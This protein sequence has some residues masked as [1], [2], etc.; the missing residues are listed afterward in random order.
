[1]SIRLWLTPIDQ[2]Y[3]RKKIS[4]IISVAALAII[5]LLI[6]IATHRLDNLYEN[7]KSTVVSD[8]NGIPILILPN[9]RG[10]YSLFANDIP[11]TFADLLISKED[12]YFYYHTGINLVGTAQLT[13]SKIGIGKRRSASTIDQQLSKVLLGHEN[14]RTIRNKI[15]ETI[16]A[17]AFD[18]LRS[19]KN[20]LLDYCNTAY[21]G[22]NIQGL[23]T[24]SLAYFGKVPE[25][26]SVEE[27]LQLLSTLSNPSYSNPLLKNN[28]ENAKILAKDLGVKAIDQ[29]FVDTDTVEHDLEA[30]KVEEN[31]FELRPYI[32]S[33]VGNDKEIKLL[34][35]SA[36][37]AQIKNIAGKILPSLSDRNAH[38]MAIVV[39]KLPEN[40]ILAMIGSPDPKST[41]YGQQIDMLEEPRQIASTV[42]PFV[43]AKAFEMGARPYT[44]IDDT[45]FKYTT[46][47]GQEYHIRNYDSKFHGRITAAYAL[48]NSINI[49]AVK[50][51]DYVGIDNFASFLSSMGYYDTKKVHDFEIGVA[52]GTI[53]MTLPELTHLYSIFPNQGKLAAMRLF[54]DPGLN[55]IA[56]PEETK[57]IIEP[58]YTQLITKILSDRYLAIDQFGY[59]SDLNLPLDNYALK[60]GTSDDYRD[61]WVIGF[62]PDF[63]VGVWVGNADDTSTKQLSGQSG[64]GEIWSQVMQLMAHTPYDK[65]TPFSFD[66]IRPIGGSGDS[67]YGLAGD[68]VEKARGLFTDA[69]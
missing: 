47:E 36:L 64:A 30:F 12:R 10:N 22:N 17:L 46:Y 23:R 42:K 67:A 68:D 11:K 13:L 16:Y 41:G 33:L 32:S 60:T 19:K 38:N 9:S 34:V 40:E 4:L 48:D 6:S 52:L 2:K 8:R 20:I 45:E 59:K 55:K 27:M 18:T 14:E 28:I 57:Q 35:D 3:S 63:I 44:L 66:Q 56:F 51:L 26:L 53:D 1:M 15:T 25:K 62:T 37:T 65:H 31:N 43:Y 24:A 50:T 61:S 69:K 7:A 39:M 5:I 29:D 58:K 49:P 21:F 54:S